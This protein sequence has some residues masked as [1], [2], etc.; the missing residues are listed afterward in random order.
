MIGD[1]E[2]DQFP[3]I[4][5]D[6]EPVLRQNPTRLDSGP[7]V[8]WDGPTREVAGWAAIRKR[9]SGI[10]R[11][12]SWPRP[13]WAF[14]CARAAV[15]GEEGLDQTQCSVAVGR[16]GEGPVMR[17]RAGRIDDV[18]HRLREAAARLCPC[19]AARSACSEAH[20]CRA[21]GGFVRGDRRGA[22]L[23]HQPG[24]GALGCMN[25]QPQ[26]FTVDSRCAPQGIGGGHSGEESTVCSRGRVLAKDTLGEVHRRRGD[27][28]EALACLGQAEELFELMQIPAWVAR[29]RAVR[30][31]TR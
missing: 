29:T 6:Y 27:E 13:R 1:I 23:R 25:P 24:D 11:S 8:L 16:R 12:R 31:S 17:L 3:P 4:V 30:S 18:G 9:G 7:T 5:E 20:P 15:R 14:K 2:G 10:L 26:E 22:P 19:L 28:E 21:I